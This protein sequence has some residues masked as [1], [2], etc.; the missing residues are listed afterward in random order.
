MSGSGW[1]VKNMKW[2]SPL[3]ILRNVVNWTGEEDKVMVMIGTED[4]M[5]GGTER[6][7]VSEFQEAIQELK[8]DKMIDLPVEK[9]N[10]VVEKVDKYVTE[11]RQGGV[12]LVEVL[13]AGHHTQNDVQWREACEA[14]RRFAA[15][16]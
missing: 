14:L 12:R 2:L 16:A 1:T 13:N 8:A 4:L 15:Q 10:K 5:M 11:E 6:R 3:D 7:M 9:E